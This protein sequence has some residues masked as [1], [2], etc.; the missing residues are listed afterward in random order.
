MAFVQLDGEY[1]ENCPEFVLLKKE[2]CL[3]SLKS[4]MNKIFVCFKL[5]CFNW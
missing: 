1:D 2:V 5:S 4:I 3:H